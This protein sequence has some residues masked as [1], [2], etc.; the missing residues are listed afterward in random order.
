VK[1][2]DLALARQRWNADPLKLSDFASATRF[3]PLVTRS[4]GKERVVE[5]SSLGS[6][7]RSLAKQG[8]KGAG[9]YIPP[10]CSLSGLG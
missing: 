8:T 2:S 6:L 3:T 5:F 4:S 7:R 10:R 9:R 1:I